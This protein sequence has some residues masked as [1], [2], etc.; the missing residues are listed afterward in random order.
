M[1]KAI[2]L[3][4]DMLQTL[5]VAQLSRRHVDGWMK[6]SGHRWAVNPSA[7]TDAEIARVVREA[8]AYYGLKIRWG[9]K[10]LDPTIAGRAMR[11]NWLA[12]KLAL[13]NKLVLNAVNPVELDTV[14]HEIA[15]LL[16]GAENHDKTFLIS[17][18]G[19]L[20]HFIGVDQETFWEAYQDAVRIS[21]QEVTGY[22]THLY[23]GTFD[24]DES[25]DSVTFAIEATG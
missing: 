15:H 5:V 12:R 19:V 17:Y 10:P 16:P 25:L 18:A 8:A 9:R 20:E 7:M 13:G 22:V 24:Y 23:D 11:P 1:L 14:L 4:S 2:V 6:R 3:S 21:R